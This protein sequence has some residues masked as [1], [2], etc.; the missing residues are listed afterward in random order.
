MPL[1]KNGVR[2]IL[3]GVVRFHQGIP[4]AENA[5]KTLPRHVLV[6]CVDPRVAPSKY[7]QLTSSEMFLIR[8][9]GNLVPHSSIVT[10]ETAATE[11]AVLELA[12]TKFNTVKQVALCGHSDCKAMNFLHG[13][14]DDP[15]MFQSAIGSKPLICETP[16]RTWIVNHGARSLAQFLRLQHSQFSIPLKINAESPLYQLEAWVDPEN[17]YN[18]TD[19]L[20]MVNCLVQME[21]IASY[22]FMKPGLQSGKTL[23]H[24]LWFD[25]EKDSVLVF[26]RSEKRFIP[27]ED[28]STIDLIVKEAKETVSKLKSIKVAVEKEALEAAIETT[29]LQSS[30]CNVDEYRSYSTLDS[31]E[32]RG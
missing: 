19:K 25:V 3:E 30:Q 29:R 23:L 13:L 22:N 16:L 18:S 32:Q 26:S 14:K 7:A 10:P 12:I 6:N 21:N 8:N 11:P 17:N 28:S 1:G 4:P 5:G 9:A 31:V 24:A 27:V 2:K 15:S 20:A